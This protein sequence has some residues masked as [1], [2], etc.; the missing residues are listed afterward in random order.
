M[1]VFTVSFAL[2]RHGFRSP[3]KGCEP[4]CCRI[5]SYFA[6]RPGSGVSILLQWGLRRTPVLVRE[7]VTALWREKTSGLLSNE[8]GLCL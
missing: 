6:L 2:Q 8:Y 7:I 1:A 3:C 4:G 5:P